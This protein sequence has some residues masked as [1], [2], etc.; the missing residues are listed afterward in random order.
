MNLARRRL[1]MGAVVVATFIAYAPALRAP[2]TFDD[3]PAIRRNT[4]LQSLRPSIALRPPPT[5]SMSGRPVANYSL[6]INYAINEWLGIDQA[7]EPASPVKTVNYHV[8][9]VLLHL[10]SAALLFGILWRTLALPRFAAWLAAKGVS[11]EAVSGAI[12]VL[13]TLHPIQSEALNYLTQRTELLVSLFYLGTLYASIRAQSAAGRTRVVWW[14]V[15]VASCALGMG[16]KEVMASAPIMVVLY[17]RAFRFPTWRSLAPNARFYA[18]LA[19]T[20]VLL[21]ALMLNDPREDAVPP[22]RAL[23]QSAHDRLR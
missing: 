15:A 16:S 9:N 23:A 8:A 5:T 21:A 10:A 17:D 4:S 2:L 19:A 14:T 22:A 18:G 7:G 3:D 20:W 6:A 1:A 11:A 12:T 13:W